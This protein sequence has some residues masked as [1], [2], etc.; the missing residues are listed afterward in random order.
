MKILLVED[1]E[2]I[3]QGLDYTLK[4]AGYDV[5]IA[6]DYRRACETLEQTHVDL[7]IMDITLPD[8]S[9]VKLYEHAVKPEGIPTIFLT[10]NDEE[11][12]IVKC[13]NIGAEDYITK[14]FKTRE[15][16]A[17]I[18][19]VV[20]V[21]N[22]NTLIKVR[23]ITFDVDKMVVTKDDKVVDLTNLELRILHLLFTNLNKV[24]KRTTLLDKIWEWTGNDIEDNTITVYMKRI[25]EKLDTDIIITLK[26][27]GYRVDEE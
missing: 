13:L 7:A 25:R 11:E 12:T 20:R 5:V 1:N 17:R 18:E 21:L 14:P 3:A 9:G 6:F 4:T 24:V 2:A 8:G 23:D 26:G 15:L 27:I 19:R 16:L 22:K 10:A